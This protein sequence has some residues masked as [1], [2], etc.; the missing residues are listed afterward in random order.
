MSETF[1]T[2]DCLKKSVSVGLFCTGFFSL[3]ICWA[4]GLAWGFI[5]QGRGFISNN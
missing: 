1:M 5:P 4:S 3:Y 2:F